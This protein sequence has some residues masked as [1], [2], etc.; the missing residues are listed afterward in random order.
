MRDLAAVLNIPLRRAR[1]S[2][3][4]P[5][6]GGPALGIIAEAHDSPSA[7]RSSGI[8]GSERLDFPTLLVDRHAHDLRHGRRGLGLLWGAEA[9]VAEDLLDGHGVVEVG[10]DFE[11]RPTF[12]AR[13][14]ISMEDFRDEPRP[15]LGTAALLRGSASAGG[16]AQP[17]LGQGCPGGCH[18]NRKIDDLLASNG[19][20]IVE[21]RT[22]YLPGPRPFTYTYEGACGLLSALPK[23]C[24]KRPRV[25]ADEC[26][27]T[28]SGSGEY[29]AGRFT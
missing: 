2:Q 15:A 1:E 28:R 8:V 11:F 14:R 9:Q 4:R 20:D 5:Q 12:A 10:N 19:F 7:G 29:R 25:D 27:R 22:A 21:L 26:A 17:C 16:P 6:A 24:S 18:L 13:E 3:D 23:T